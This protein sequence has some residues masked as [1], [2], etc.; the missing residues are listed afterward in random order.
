MLNETAGFHQTSFMRE[1]S[2]SWTPSGNT[3]GRIYVLCPLSPWRVRGY[4]LGASL[5]SLSDRVNSSR[6]FQSSAVKGRQIHTRGVDFK[7]EWCGGSSGEMIRSL[8]VL[9]QV[10]K[11]KK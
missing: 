11:V 1:A 4:R 7:D 8:R 6:V 10:G 9:K 5:S 3:R 2:V